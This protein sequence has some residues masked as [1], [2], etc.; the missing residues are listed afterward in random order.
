MISY[1]FKIYSQ[2]IVLE[3]KLHFAAPCRKSASVAAA[4][5]TSR[6][7]TAEKLLDFGKWEKLSKNCLQKVSKLVF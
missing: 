7:I 5:R 3:D 2:L 4:E 6:V 1:L